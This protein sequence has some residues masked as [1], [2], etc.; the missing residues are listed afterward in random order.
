[1]NRSK[2]EEP[3]QP[4]NHEFSTDVE[5]P[6]ENPEPPETAMPFP[7]VCRSRKPECQDFIGSLFSTTVPKGS[8]RG[9]TQSTKK[10]FLSQYSHNSNFSRNGAGFRI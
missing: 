2:W 8:T 10:K 6:V 9:S 5:M 7:L 3:G 1:M 4:S